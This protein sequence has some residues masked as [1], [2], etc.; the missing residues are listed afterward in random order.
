MRKTALCIGIANCAADVFYLVILALKTKKKKNYH[1]IHADIWVSWAT[2]GSGGRLFP[3][4]D[5]KL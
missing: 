3:F 1:I 5:F 2:A 4:L